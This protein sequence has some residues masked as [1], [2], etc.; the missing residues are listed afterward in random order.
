MVQSLEVLNLA[1]N[2]FSGDVPNSFYDLSQLKRLYLAKNLF[3]GEVS[4]LTSLIYLEHLDLRSNFFKG[5]LPF[6]ELHKH[7]RFVDLSNNKFTGSIPLEI[8]EMR[9][10]K[11]LMLQDNVLTGTI[12]TQIGFLRNLSQFSLAYNNFKG[13]MPNEMFALENL[14]LLHLHS[15]DIVGDADKFNYNVENYITDCGSTTS[16]EALISCEKCTFCCND[17]L[18]CQDLKAAWPHGL[19]N[20]LKIPAATFVS[21]VTFSCCLAFVVINLIFIYNHIGKKLR[22]LKYSRNKF[23]TNSVYKFLLTNDWRAIF[24]ALLMLAFHFIVLYMFLDA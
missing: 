21:M 16:T 20:E 18:E 19:I 23:Q 9:F 22:S 24:F 2:S 4:K 5:K 1:N 6:G 10:L 14:K 15:N 8:E 11:V 7:M 12:P 13:S 3:S 17:F